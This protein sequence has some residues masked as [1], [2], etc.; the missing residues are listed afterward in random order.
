MNTLQLVWKNISQQWGSSLLSILLTAFGVSI[1]VVI[2]VTGDTF[3]K[4]LDNNSKNIDLVVGAK[5]SPLQIILSSVYHVDYPTGN[6]LLDDAMQLRDNPLVDLAVP[7]SLGDNYR[8]HRIVGTDSTFLE[9]Y[10]LE[11][12]EGNI[13]THNYEALIGSEVARKNSLKI[14]DQIYSAHGLSAE[15]HV[16]DEHPFTVVGILASTGTVVDNLVLCDL[17]SIWDVHGIHHEHDDHHDHDHEHDH[18]PHE[19]PAHTHDHEHDHH[20]HE[21]TD[22]VPQ[23][24]KADTPSQEHD[25]GLEED[26]LVSPGDV[27]QG[28]TYVKSIA[29]DVYKTPGLEVTSVLIRYSSPAAI[30]VLPR[31]INQS[32]TMQ[33]ASPAMETTRLFS[34]LGVGLDSLEILAYVIMIIAGLSVFISLYNALKE[35]KYDLALMRTLG[36]GKIKL[37]GLVIVEGL[38]I[39]LV[40][41]LIGLLLGH[42][43]LVYISGQ[44][45]ESADFI[46][47]FNIN[48]REWLILVIASAIGILAAIIPAVKA[49]NT[50]IST[51]LGSK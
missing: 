41:G 28:S 1:L 23:Q 37:F 11:I 40:G 43:A 16:H 6:I 29:E 13:W 36:A 50:T 27:N 5:G 49:Y 9:L 46:N 20:D 25:H 26:T 17:Q 51:I 42:V 2:Y 10:E 24:Q 22:E 38:V 4:Q 31:M 30:S 8:G 35:R 21:H 19:T 48:P 14:G 47:A 45:S 18:G 7:V 39:T 32:T 15:G 44:A 33:A 12:T 3:E 34:L